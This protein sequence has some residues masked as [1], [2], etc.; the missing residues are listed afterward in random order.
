MLADRHTNTQR[1]KCKQTDIR[2][3]ML[4]SATDGGVNI[5][6]ISDNFDCLN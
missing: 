6:Y 2:I 3:T 1:E 4:R 5:I